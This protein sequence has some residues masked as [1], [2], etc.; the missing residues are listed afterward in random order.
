MISVTVTLPMSS[1]SFSPLIL[2]TLRGS[3]PCPGQRPQ[4]ASGNPLSTSCAL[5]TFRTQNKHPLGWSQGH[6][7]SNSTPGWP[8]DSKKRTEHPQESGSHL[9]RKGGRMV[10]GQSTGG[11]RPLDPKK[12]A[13]DNH[14]G[15]QSRFWRAPSLHLG[16]LHRSVDLKSGTQLASG[17]SNI[18]PNPGITDASPHLWQRSTCHWEF[19]TLCCFLSSRFLPSFLLGRLHPTVC[20]AHLTLSP[21]LAI[22]PSLPLFKETLPESHRLC[23]YLCIHQIPCFPSTL[24]GPRGRSHLI[25]LYIPRAKDSVLSKVGPSINT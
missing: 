18:S 25:Y 14:G 21:R 17:G 23:S 10:Q 13:E 3:R 11:D 4:E 1:L 5:P 16:S 2:I 7:P 9:R 15:A 22:F 19:S 24:P 20:S 12:W 6:S 8:V